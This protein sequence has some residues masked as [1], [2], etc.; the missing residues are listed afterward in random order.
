MLPQP[1][2]LVPRT[3]AARTAGVPAPLTIA[4][5]RA[6]TAE[7]ILKAWF[8]GKSANT[9]R[10]YR[11]D[12]EAFALYLSR[13]L[14]ISPPMDVHA[15]VS[16]LFKQSAPSAH[17]IVLGFRH[18]LET[19]HLSASGINRH[20]ATLRSVTKLGRML[21]M[22]TWYL[23]VPGVKAEKRRKT[24]GPT[25]ADVRRLLDATSGD[26]EADTRDHAIIW[27]FYAC[28]LRVSELCGL[29]LQ[30]TDLVRGSTWIKGKGRKEKELIPLPAPVLAAIRRYLTYRGTSAGPLFQSRGYRGKNRDGRLETRSVLRIVRKAGQRV[31][32]H[33]WCHGLRHSSISAALDAAARVG[34]SMDKVRAHSRH[35]AIAT[36]LVYADEHDRE[37][38]QRTLADLVASTLTSDPSR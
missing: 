30:E 15:A 24:A 11:H 37:R 2:G 33:V 21:G 9:I 5:G 26:T 18:Y 3:H 7:T 8:Q 20:I 23:E 28:G 34:M 13:A 29:T 22:M 19:A 35:A 32:L 31:G 12:L 4:A 17:E 14:G 16:R 6:H 10:S 1:Q 27:T 25:V 36:L 38:T